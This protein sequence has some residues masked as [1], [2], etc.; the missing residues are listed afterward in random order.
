[1]TKRK[2]YKNDNPVTVASEPAIAYVASS[3]AQETVGQGSMT[4][5]EY[6]DRVREALDDRY[7]AQSPTPPPCQ[8]TVEEMVQRVIQATADVDAGRDLMSHDEF[9][10]L[11]RSW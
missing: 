3:S 11:V 9:A 6:F 10:K 7:A 2:E 5:D 8:Y 4:V 1:M